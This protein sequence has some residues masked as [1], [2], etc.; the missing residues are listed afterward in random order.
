MDFDE[1]P[2]EAAFRAE[3]HAWLATNAVPK[4]HPDDFS[5]G[6]RDG[7]EAEYVKRCKEWQG[8]LA[9]GGWA[10]ITW[11]KEYGGRGGTGTQAAIFAE[12]QAKFGVSNGIFAV[13]IG[14]AGPTIIAHGTPEQKQRFLP[15][16]LHGDEVWCQLFSE[17]GAGSDLANL[18]CRAVRDGDEWVVNGQKVWTSG[19]QNSDW[20]IL[21]AR[22]DPDQPKHR[23]ITYFL[24]DMHSAGI[25]IRPLRQMTGGSH[26]NEVF[27]TDVRI[28]QENVLGDVNAGW[29]VAM[30]TLANERVLIGGGGSG[31]G[32]K[33]LVA[34][35]QAN[36]RDRD[37]LVRQG[38]AAAYTRYEII[39]Y[40]GMRVRT[41]TSKGQTP[42]AEASVMKL[43]YAGHLKKLGDL[44]MSIEGAAGSLLG[45]DAPAGGTWQQQLL[46]APSIR[47]AGGSDE[48]QRNIMGERVLGLPGEPRV[49]K[50]VAW[51][52]TQRQG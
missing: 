14:M 2:E 28:P 3:A 44:A 31:P 7:D 46:S 17:P 42:G 50:G 48:V 49:D 41:A 16:L 5:V 12:E 13:G 37:A 47:I 40:L 15:P 45:R 10:C 27:L 30:T 23:G 39:R 29:G 51:R 9:E 18:G 36:D 24:V 32:F 19:A 22:T 20:G 38:L 21:L 26:F 43:F 4:G 52:D 33:D 1:S 35:A 6:F 34:L 11:P 8:R 25:E